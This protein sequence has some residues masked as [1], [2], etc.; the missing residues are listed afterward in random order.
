MAYETTSDSTEA[1]LVTG[2]VGTGK[3][4]RLVERAAALLAENAAAGNVLVLC[5][6]PQAARLFSE[7]LTARVGAKRAAGA[8]VATARALALDVL[9]DDGARRWSG[10]EPRLL[11]AFEE[12]FL[13][14]DMKVSGLRPKRLRE[15]LKFFYRSWTEL[16]DDDPD[17]RGGRCPYAVEREPGLHARRHRTRSGE[18]CCTL[19]PRTRRSAGGAFL[20]ARADGRLRLRKPCL[21]D[22]GESRR[23]LL[24]H[25]G[26]RRG[27]LHRD[28]RFVPL[29]RRNRRI[30]RNASRCCLRA[31]GCRRARCRRTGR[32]GKR[33]ARSRV[34]TGGAHGGRSRRR[35]N[36]RTADRRGRTEQ[37]VVAQHRNRFARTRRANRSARHLAA[38]ARRR[39]GQRP[40]HACA[41]RHG[42]QPRGEP[43]RHRGLAVL[44]W[45]RRLPGEQRGFRQPADLREGAQYRPRGRFGDA[46]RKR[47]RARSGRATRGDRLQGRSRAHRAGT[48]IA[49]HGTAGR[50]DAHRHRRS[51]IP[52][53]RRS[54]RALPRARQ[55]SR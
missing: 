21:A 40:L 19:P 1:L 50:A 53:A 45:I 42:P 24:D 46:K 28:I 43:R 25:R 39:A 8:T 54:A 41:H 49:G 47:L 18:P 5:A 13:M 6:T 4:Q 15:M 9:A 29:C 3:T 35:R 26:G 16:A 33:H 31:P 38:P 17:W 55:R 7:R 36:A 23:N 11:T 30:P 22:A 34:R 48:R 32:S 2:G 52:S 37:R 14:E 12:T 10:R 20:R 27:N 44:V 51:G